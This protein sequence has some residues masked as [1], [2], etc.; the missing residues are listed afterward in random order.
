MAVWQRIIN[1]KI[2][3]ERKKIVESFEAKNAYSYN[4]GMELKG[5]YGN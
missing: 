2:E 5:I 4:S 1:Q 3:N